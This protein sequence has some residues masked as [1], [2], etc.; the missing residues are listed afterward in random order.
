MA[1]NACKLF[2]WC[3]ALV[4]A[5]GIGFGQQSEEPTF[6]ADANLVVLDVQVLNASEPLRTLGPSDFHI[7]DDG[8]NRHIKLFEYGSAPLDVAFVVDI[9]EGV[10]RTSAPEWHSSVQRAFSNIRS[11][12]RVGVLSF[13][14]DAAI[15]T[16]LSNDPDVWDDAIYDALGRRQRQGRRSKPNIYGALST[17]GSL[18]DEPRSFRRRVVLLVSHNMGAVDREAA[19]LVEQQY[20]SR[21]I[22]LQI[23][24]VP[25]YKSAITT[26]MG[27]GFSDEARANSGS[28]ASSHHR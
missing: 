17:A 13:S 3:A 11:G 7:T 25:T 28:D 12:D 15:H 20:S 19:Q 1:M 16:R 27:V 10:A 6:R 24:V 5:A 23:V 21:G 14:T 22:T 9:S 26:E 4:L 18:F 2:L 8:R